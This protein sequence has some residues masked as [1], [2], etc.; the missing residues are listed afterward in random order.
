MAELRD[1]IDMFDRLV[2]AAADTAPRADVERAAAVAR[3]VRSRRGYA[4][5]TVVVALA[6]GTGSGKSSTI[7]AL[8][9]EEVALSG[10]LRPTTSDPQ[11]WIPA[12]PEAGVIR[13]LDDV[14]IAERVGQD[15]FDWLAVIDL[16]DTDSV[17][18]DHRQTVARL[19]P[20]VDVVVWVLDPEKYQDRVL[21]RDHLAALSDYGDQFLFVLNQIDRLTDA[22]VPELVADLRQ[23]LEAD[24][25]VD[26]V[27]I[28]TAADPTIGPP[29]GMDDLV[30][31]LRGL[32]ETKAVIHRKLVKDLEVAAR[33]L[34]LAAG[35]E[36][37]RGTGFAAEWD[38]VVRDVSA[39]ITDDVAGKPVLQRAARAGRSSHRAAMSLLRRRRSPGTVELSRR[40]DSGPGSL[41]AIRRL[42][43]YVSDLA[44]RVEG[45]VAIAVRTVGGEID[46]AVSAAVDAVAFGE[47][48]SIPAPPG[49]TAGVAWFRRI[50]ALVAVVA[51]L[52]TFDVLRSGGPLLVPV[53]VTLGALLA[54]LLSGAIGAGIGGREAVK[55]VSDQRQAITRSVSR[56]IDRRLGRPLREVLRK[57]A[58]VAAAL[59]EF[60]LVMAEMENG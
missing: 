22:Q 39:R 19:L 16:P 21:H 53:S 27:I 44:G 42:D 10:A 51:G 40:P 1:A 28:P 55:V 34:A 20:E 36:G 41:A 6:G 31:A 50:M 54:V 58:G 52:W 45:D 13:L 38:N 35:V 17:V 18:I 37:G 8:A 56:E 25:I 14:G 15:R 43:S 4:G 57:R 23:S 5:S 29:M 60:E 11:A 33:E 2:A 12:D 3:R 30:L 47:T 59:A 32:G 24:G 7:N 26:P 48:V 46:G 9:E 49:W